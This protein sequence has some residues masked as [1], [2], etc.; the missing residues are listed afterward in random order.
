MNRGF[1]QA[2]SSY[3]PVFRSI[4]LFLPVLLSFSSFLSFIFS[5]S[6]FVSSFAPPLLSLALALF[7]SQTLTLPP[8]ILPSTASS[9]FSCIDLTLTHSLFYYLIPPKFAYPLLTLVLSPSLNF[10]ISSSFTLF[11]S[12]L[13]SQN[14]FLL[15]Q[16]T[17]AVLSFPPSPFLPFVLSNFS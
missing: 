6:S 9:P 3:I 8:P 1:A 17:F 11:T 13:S 14:S 10:R 2:V 7:L 16:V 5:Q 15:F 12:F 4:Q